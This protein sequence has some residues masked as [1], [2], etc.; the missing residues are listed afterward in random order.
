VQF[1][2][3]IGVV[4]ALMIGAIDDILAHLPRIRPVLRILIMG[5]IGFAAAHVGHGGEGALYVRLRRPRRDPIGGR[6]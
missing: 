3:L 5:V 6:Q 2:Y 1:S 4:P